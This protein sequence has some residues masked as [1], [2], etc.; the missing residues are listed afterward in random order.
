MK[1]ANRTRWLA[2]PNC[3]HSH[4]LHNFC[5]SHEYLIHCQS[6]DFLA[7]YY[8]YLIGHMDLLMMIIEFRM[9]SML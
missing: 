4:L 3:A 2:N 6:E 9:V 7:L 1:H 8:L 5:S